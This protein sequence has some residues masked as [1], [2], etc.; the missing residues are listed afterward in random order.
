MAILKSACAQE[1]RKGNEL[2][3]EVDE[4]FFLNHKDTKDTKAHNEYPL[5]LFVPLVSLWFNWNAIEQKLKNPLTG[6]PDSCLSQSHPCQLKGRR[7]NPK[8]VT[9]RSFYD[10]SYSRKRKA[11]IFS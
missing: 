11:Y 4:L 9:C 3:R 10:R 6:D 5:C 2:R 1:K 7:V 8:D